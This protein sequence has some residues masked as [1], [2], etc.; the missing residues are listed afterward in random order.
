MG[1]LELKSTEGATIVEEGIKDEVSENCPVCGNPAWS[2]FL[3]APDRYH[4]R[5]QPYY[6]RRC[7]SCSLVWLAC[8]P[9]HE[10]MA[11]H[12]GKDYYDGVSSAGETPDRWREQWEVIRRY[13]QGGD[14]LDIGCSS[15][16]FLR[17]FKGDSWRLHGIEIAPEMAERARLNTAG[18]IFAGDALSAPFAPASFDVVTCFDVLEHVHDPQGLLGKVMEW[19]RPG[20]IF[21]TMLP[22]IDSW[23][24]KMCRS[25]WYGLELPRHLFHFSPRSLKRAMES[26]GF[27]QGHIET[28]RG[29]YLQLS[30]RYLYSDVLEK[31]G[32]AVQPLAK[33]TQAPIPWRIVRKVMRLSVINPFGLLAAKCG[34][35]AAMRAIFLKPTTK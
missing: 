34:A 18:E 20:G 13:K 15:G 16:G 17:T 21:Y 11:L 32:F 1:S 26:A 10:E 23:E 33:A 7:D 28:Q 30:T 24:A 19:L 35:G 14:F 2:N 5:R 12:Y 31:L 4:L 27:G 3:S 9:A 6:L 29:S 25:Y 8:P 22:N